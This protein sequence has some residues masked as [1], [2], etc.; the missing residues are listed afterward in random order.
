MDRHR[1]WRAVVHDAQ[2]LDEV[3]PEGFEPVVLAFIRGRPE[4]VEVGYVET[5][6]K[7]DYPWVRLQTLNASDAGE[8]TPDGCLIHVHEDLVE[9]IEIHYR[10]SQGKGPIGFTH[11]VADIPEA[12]S[13]AE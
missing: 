2:R 13:S 8:M 6:R 12:E 3:A 1:I 7:P 11:K 10:R 5:S 4:S 9:R